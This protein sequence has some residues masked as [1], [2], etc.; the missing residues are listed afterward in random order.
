MAQKTSEKNLSYQI[1]TKPK[2]A[3]SSSIKVI[4]HMECAVNFCI[5]SNLK[6]FKPKFLRSSTTSTGSETNNIG[7]FNSNLSY[8]KLINDLMSSSDDV[9]QLPEQIFIKRYKY[10][11]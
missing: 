5:K 4:A 3:N 1:T 7:S 6:F 11:Y 9:N 8:R 10:L 2:I